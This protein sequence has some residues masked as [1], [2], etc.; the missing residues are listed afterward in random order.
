MRLAF[1]LPA[2]TPSNNQLL[3]MHWRERCKAKLALSWEVKGVTANSDWASTSP[4]GLAKVTILRVGKKLLDRDNLY[5]GAKLLV[6]R[7]RPSRAGVGRRL[8]AYRLDG[9]PGDRH[10][11]TDAGGA[12]GP[13][14]A[15]SVSPQ[16]SSRSF[17]GSCC[18][19]CASCAGLRR[20]WTPMTTWS[21]TRRRACGAHRGAWQTRTRSATG[22]GRGTS[23]AA[24]HST[25]LKGAVGSW[26]VNRSRRYWRRTV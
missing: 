22:G 14:S 13:M 3:R 7:D 23:T 1:E 24:G 2:P 6:R 20:P 21:P 18:G 16:G 26:T 5:G 19:L 25:W 9:R 12:G 15:L 10:T 8:D 17:G 11:P 4:P